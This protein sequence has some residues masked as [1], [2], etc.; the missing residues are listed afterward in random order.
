M[1]NEGQVVVITGASSGIGAAVARR[2]GARGDR[3]VLAAR[4]E[5]E[6]AQVAR[7]SATEA[8]TVIT[9][10]R[11]RDQVDRLKSQALARFGRVDVW[12]NN[13]G[14]GIGYKVLDLT[15]ADFDEM[16]AVNVK[17]AL[18]GM[19][20]IVPHF[21]ERERGHLINISSYL[22]R[23]PAVSF[24]SGYNAAKHAL[25]ALTANLRM[26]LRKF[27][28]IHVSLVMP[29]LVATE[30]QQ[31][32]L[33]GTPEPPLPGGP[34]QTQTSDE[35]A[36]AIEGVIDHPQAELY[37]NPAQ[38]EM[39]LRYFADVEKFEAGMVTP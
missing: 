1:P 39:V 11:H 29:G 34:I 6:L 13:A 33:G 35:V 18:F 25:N 5:P 9:D 23:V 8:L 37:T 4:R 7:D 3:L 16:M 36:A 17:S 22:S 19:Q 26:D 32:A 27:T 31:N 15:E 21:M 20:A 14:R 2:L 28:A 24:R 30:F 10:V 12:I 38:R